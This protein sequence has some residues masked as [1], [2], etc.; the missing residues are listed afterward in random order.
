M[1]P[2]NDMG[3]FM[4]KRMPPAFMTHV[5]DIMN[6]APWVPC[7]FFTSSLPCFTTTN[8]LYAAFSGVVYPK[9]F[10]C[11]STPPAPIPSAHLTRQTLAYQSF[12]CTLA[13]CGVSDAH[14]LV[15]PPILVIIHLR[16]GSIPLPTLGVPK[17]S[18]GFT[19]SS[20]YGGHIGFFFISAISDAKKKT[21]GTLTPTP[22][23]IM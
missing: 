17:M 7:P 20:N 5:Q 1:D 6:N 15:S 19:S 18:V 8:L 2:I 22:K 4:A 23:K 12:C 14:Q 16:H 21:S 3:M 13:I 9:F 10:G 11:P